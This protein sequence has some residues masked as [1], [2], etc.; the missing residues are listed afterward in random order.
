MSQI[1]LRRAANSTKMRQIDFNVV[2]VQGTATCNESENHTVDAFASIIDWMLEKDRRVKY[3]TVCTHPEERVYEDCF[4]DLNPQLKHPDKYRYCYGDNE[5]KKKLDEIEK[6]LQE[7]GV[8]LNTFMLRQIFIF[9]KNGISGT[10]TITVD[11]EVLVKFELNCHGEQGKQ[12]S[13]K[14]NKA[15]NMQEL[16]DR[17]K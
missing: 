7:A 10:I 6:F 5:L 15:P 17:I 2:E 16:I 1:P 4:P 14:V 8:L 11:D 12:F 3:L 9:Y 13:I